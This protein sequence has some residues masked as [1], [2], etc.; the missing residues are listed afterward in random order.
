M[1]L[2]ERRRLD[3]LGR[4]FS[5]PIPCSWESFMDLGLRVKQFLV[6]RY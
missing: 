1:R 5:V 6:V 3:S 4:Q 2:D